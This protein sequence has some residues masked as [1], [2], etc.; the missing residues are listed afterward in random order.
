[1]VSVV[2][3]AMDALRREAIQ[4]GKGNIS[5]RYF[6]KRCEYI[7]PIRQY[8]EG[9][10][11]PNYDDFLAENPQFKRKFEEHDLAVSKIE[12]AAGKFAADLLHNEKF[13]FEVDRALKNYASESTY[14]RSPSEPSPPSLEDTHGLPE[15]IA[16]YVI[17]N[18]E[19]LPRHYLTYDFWERFR[20]PF[21]RDFNARDAS[22]ADALPRA[23]QQLE[24]ISGRLARDLDR[25]RLNL[26]RKHDMAPVPVPPPNPVEDIT[27]RR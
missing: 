11:R 10:Y 12:D 19:S 22:K 20:G 4:L 18:V 16:E 14:A 15:T 1:M 27:S 6:S 5:W 7:R 17:N 9:A 3:P 24:G 2:N 8:I 21:L 26:C 23:V 13:K 25:H